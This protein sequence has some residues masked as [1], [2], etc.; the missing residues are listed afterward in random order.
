MLKLTKRGKK[1]ICHITGTV[2]GQRVREYR[3]GF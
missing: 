1:G 3:H 2:G